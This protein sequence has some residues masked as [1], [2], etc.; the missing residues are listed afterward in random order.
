MNYKHAPRRIYPKMTIDFSQVLKDMQGEALDHP[1][2]KDTKF[3]LADAVV[4][5]LIVPDEEGKA[6]D[7]SEKV[8]RYK[9]AQKIVD[10]GEHPVSVEEAKTI[11]D[12][13]N[14][15]YGPLIVGQVFAAM[16]EV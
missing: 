14:R 12:T 10:G 16:G 4:A 9:L 5:A 1:V 15:I 2:K 13:C 11:Q 6:T 7:A 3:T 8:R